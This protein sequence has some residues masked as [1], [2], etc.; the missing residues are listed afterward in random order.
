MEYSEINSKEDY[1]T[2]IEETAVRIIF[3]GLPQIHRTLLEDEIA[4]IVTEVSHKDAIIFYKEGHDIILEHS[5]NACAIEEHEGYVAG[6]DGMNDFK[7]IKQ[8]FARWAFYTDIHESVGDKEATRNERA[9]ICDSCGSQEVESRE[10]IDLNVGHKIARDIMDLRET[11]CR[12]CE[13]IECVSL[14]QSRE[15]K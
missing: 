9:W 7:D 12:K 3:R 4:G 5:L 6:L 11:W 8:K 1:D 15:V 14:G 13:G 10:W 2:Y